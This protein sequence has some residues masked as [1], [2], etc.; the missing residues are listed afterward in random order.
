MCFRGKHW[1][2]H[3]ILQGITPKTIEEFATRTHD[4]ELSMS[5][6]LNEVPLVHELRKVNES[7]EFKKMGKYF[8]RLKTM[9]PRNSILLM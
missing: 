8:Q 2:L 9:N 5:S 4:M 7:Q 6:V 1:G 3:Y